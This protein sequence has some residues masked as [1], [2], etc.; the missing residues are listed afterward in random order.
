MFF[1]LHSENRIGYKE[2]TDADL[3]R[4][5]TSHQ[6]HI[7]LFDDVL[8]YLPNFIELDDAMV[9]YNDKV[10][11]MAVSFDR[12]ENPDHSFRSPKIRTGGKG[13]VS[14]VSF[15]RDKAKYSSSQTRWFLFW[16]GLKSEQPVFFFFN[17]SSSTY[18]D[19][20]SLG[21]E[22]KPHVKS[23]LEVNNPI[24]SVILK[25]LENVVNKS[26][27]NAV[28][29]L[30]LVA[31]GAVPIEHNY[32]KYDIDRATAYFRDIGREGEELVDNY[33]A[34]QLRKRYIQNY[35][36][37]NKE[38][39]SGKPY[40]F[41][42]EM[43][44]GEIIYLDVKNTHYD[45]EQKMIFSSQEIQF[46]S[47]SQYKYQIYRVYGDTNNKFLKICDNAKP[48]FAT[49]HGRTCDFEKNI[50][51]MASVETIKLAIQPCQNQLAFGKE[52]SL[53]K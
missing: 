6:T 2:L 20:V 22:L 43:N 39:E 33:F 5:P 31:Q 28:R 36:W 17:D 25:Y 44:N 9:I 3:G 24:F 35:C 34:E 7:G 53:F 16:F 38:V 26:G 10:D 47:E 51:N 23:R 30:E 8:T 1:E 14:V 29:E 49:I 48:L 50:H 19:I 12:I 37:V 27:F 15:I 41:Y 46:V 4:S 42:F 21:V 40:D 11:I 32:R 18:S 13:T 52:I 45:F